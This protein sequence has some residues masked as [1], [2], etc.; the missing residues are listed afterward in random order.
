M[1]KW[2]TM[3]LAILKDCLIT[4]DDHNNNN[5]NNNNDSGSGDNENQRGMKSFSSPF[6]LRGSKNPSRVSL[7]Y[8]V[9]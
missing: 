5:N 3:I 4:I 8:S 1:T 7:Y 2:P 9:L 6:P